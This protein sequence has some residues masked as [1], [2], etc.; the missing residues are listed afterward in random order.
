[1]DEAGLSKPDEEPFLVVAGVIIQGDNVLNGVEA[2]LERIMKRHIPT[3]HW[4]NF[5]FHATELFNGGKVFKRHK[6]DFIGPPQWPLNRRLDIADEIML[7]PKKFGLSLALGWV[8][9][10][11]FA[12]RLGIPN[13]WALAEMATAQQV[14]AFSTC[15]MFVEQ[16]MRRNASNEN[17]LL[18]VEN[19]EKAKSLMRNTQQ[20]HQNKKVLEVVDDFGK[21]LVPFRKIRQDPLFQDKRPSNALIIADFCAYVWKKVLMEDKRY[22]RFLEPIKKQIVHFGD[23]VLKEM[24]ERAKK[25]TAS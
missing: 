1:M 7:I 11:T 4:D 3:G 19:N 6:P 5:V 23:G 2:Q 21:Q 10:S 18:I 13:S 16:W 17:C 14:A 12:E 25:R 15:S 20:W 24:A 22:V 8:E 9:R